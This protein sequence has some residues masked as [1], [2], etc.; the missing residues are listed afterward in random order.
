MLLKYTL[1]LI[2]PPSTVTELSLI[3]YESYR[4]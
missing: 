2:Q 4:P 3:F 1:D